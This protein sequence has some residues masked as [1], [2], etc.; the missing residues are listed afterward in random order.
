MA[1][2]AI[3]EFEPGRMSLHPDEYFRRAYVWEIP[4]RLTH[5]VNAV[6]LI[7]LF[8]TGLYISHPLLAPNGEAVRHF[9]MGRAR[10]IHFIAAM[11]FTVSFLVRIYWFWMGNAYARSG[12][13]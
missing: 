2:S 5:W 6:C 11:L 7:V 8:L 4:V 13:P 12:F 10:Q 3:H 9:V 1:S